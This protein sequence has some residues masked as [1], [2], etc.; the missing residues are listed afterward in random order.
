MQ[1]RFVIVVYHKLEVSKLQDEAT[2][3]SSLFVDLIV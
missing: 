2:Y 1:R 3:L